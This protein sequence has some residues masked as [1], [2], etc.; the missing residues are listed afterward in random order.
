MKNELEIIIY[1]EFTIYS[2][3][4][5][6]FHIYNLPYEVPLSLFYIERNQ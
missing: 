1:L 6:S 2:L 5:I 3:L 4:Y